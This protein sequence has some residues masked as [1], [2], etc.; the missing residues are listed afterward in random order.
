MVL[1]LT[2][3]LLTLLSI[4]LLQKL[5]TLFYN[6]FLHPLR[7]F[8]G[9]PYVWTDWYKCYNDVYLNRN[10]TDVLKELHEKYGDVVRVGANELHF[11][12]PSVYN[13]LYSPTHRWDKDGALYRVF[14]QDESSFGYLTYREAKARKDILA[15]LF[16]HRATCEMQGIVKKHLDRMC[17]ALGKRE[18]SSDMLFALRSFSLDCITTYCFAKD[19]HA[20]SAEDFK[21]PLVEAMDAAVPAIR[22][23]QYFN[24][25]RKL[26]FGL[27][28]WLAKLTDPNAGARVELQDM[29]LEQVKEFVE[30]PK[31]MEQTSNPTIY[32]RLLDPSNGPVPSLKSLHDEA[33]SL[34][35]GG[36]ESS[37]NVSMLGTW[38]ILQNPSIESRLREELREAWPDLE[39]MPRLEDLEKLP[40]L[41]AVIKESLRLS[42][43]V[44]VPL[45]RVVP[46]QGATL[47][48]HPIPGGTIVGMSLRFVHQSE[49]IFPDP[50]TFNPDRWLGPDASSLNKWLVAFSKGPTNCIGQNLA[51]CELY[52]AFAALFRRFELVLDGTR[53]EDLTYSEG[54]LP[55]FNPRHMRAFCRPVEA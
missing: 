50:Q 27:P 54:F 2:T 23:L 38:Y 14:N 42:P 46:P 21:H 39:D 3:F 52:M 30:D 4:P 16:S 8:P 37:G 24:P 53:S 34:F 32:H 47:S 15:P 25:W 7:T 20:S 1:T 5:Y 11:S 40:Y 28:P 43:S 45:P 26:V 48:N 9:P 36:A 12:N 49:E 44:P 31:R 35:F 19:V 18:E 13:D 41:T 10:W 33:M 55:F 51:M 29:L 22:V 6:A 17:E